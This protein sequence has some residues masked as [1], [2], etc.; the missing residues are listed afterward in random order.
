MTLPE[1]CESLFS[2]GLNLYS[3]CVNH[4]C[5]CCWCKVDI[6]DTSLPCVDWSPTGSGL[7]LLGKTVD[8][9]LAYMH[10]QLLAGTKIIFFE[11]VPEFPISILNA[12]TGHKYRW[13]AFY[14][15]PAD[16]GYEFVNGTR[17]F[18][19]GILIGHQTEL[20]LILFYVVYL[21]SLLLCLMI[22]KLWQ[23]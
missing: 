20:A 10:Y 14:M 16:V 22:H 3:W 18:A 2:C 5:W 13:C 21:M 15:E 9:I 23:Q 8:V 6:D 1:K 19:L 11:N 12:F 4:A 17:M 7:G